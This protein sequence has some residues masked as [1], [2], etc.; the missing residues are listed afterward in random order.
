MKRSTLLFVGAVMIVSFQNC[1]Q[2]VNFQSESALKINSSGDPSLPEETLP[3]P[4][5][6]STAGAEVTE[7]FKVA[8]NSESAPLDMIW[9][10]DNSGS[11]KE[12]IDS[13][14][15]NFNTF[16]DT[17]NKN[18][19]FKMLLISAQGTSGFSISIPAKYDPKNH[20]QVN[21]SVGSNNGPQILLDELNKLPPDF[22]RMDSKKIVVFVTDDNSSLSSNTV[23]TNLQSQQGWSA[24]DISVT[25][26]IGIDTSVSK[27]AARPGAVYKDLATATQGKFYNIC[28]TDWSSYFADLTNVSVSK[29]IRRFVLKDNARDILEVKING[30]ILAKDLYTVDG[31]AVTLSD[32]VVLVENAEVQVR[33]K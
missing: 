20:K 29:A 23:L 19:N 28:N 6:N 15:K 7:N 31:K 11:M 24:Q 9:V 10:I 5:P 30:M 32:Q 22:L 8:F 12:E 14:R 3:T 18:T 25:S 27:C 21:R 33:Y 26:F 2:N 4:T 16:L 17:L 1:A 13:V